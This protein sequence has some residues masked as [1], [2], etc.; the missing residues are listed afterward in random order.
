MTE[1]RT[2]QVDQI[3]KLKERIFELGRSIQLYS[4]TNLAKETREASQKLF[5]KVIFRLRQLEIDGLAFKV[6]QM[7][8]VLAILRADQGVATPEPTKT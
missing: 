7:E 5:D 8:K 3:K 2:P 4:N 1:K 6:E